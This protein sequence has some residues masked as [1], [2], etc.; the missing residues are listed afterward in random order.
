MGSRDAALRIEQFCGLTT[1][2]D[3]EM[4]RVSLERFQWKG[5]RWT[6]VWIICLL[7]TWWKRW[8]RL[9]RSDWLWLMHQ[10]EMK[11]T[12]G[13]S[14]GSRRVRGGWPRQT[15]SLANDWVYS[16]HAS[17]G[18]CHHGPRRWWCCLPFIDWA[19]SIIALRRCCRF[20]FVLK[21]DSHIYCP[22]TQKLFNKVGLLPRWARAG[23]FD[24]LLNLH[25]LLPFA[26]LGCKRKLGVHWQFDI[27]H[28]AC[29]QLCSNFT[30]DEMSVVGGQASKLTATTLQDDRSLATGSGWL[31]LRFID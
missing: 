14:K 20:F 21:I 4:A 28:V 5:W 24:L 10:I 2:V 15:G 30:R 7:E 23:P 29:P 26:C 13:S 25:F 16:S 11:V 3:C 18:Q 9:G 22:V 17:F 12:D 1:P 19:H 27:V 31:W 6:C 8:V